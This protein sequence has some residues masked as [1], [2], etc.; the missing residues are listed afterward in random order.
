VGRSRFAVTLRRE[1]RGAAREGVS[2]VLLR[3][4]PGLQKARTRT[5]NALISHAP[6]FR[7]LLARASQ[8]PLPPLTRRALSLSLA[9]S[10]GWRR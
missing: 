5:H 8:L 7:V 9:R 3:G 2:P 4:E 6:V 1:I 10:N